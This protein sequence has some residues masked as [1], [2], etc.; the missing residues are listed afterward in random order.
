MARRRRRCM[1]H[2]R[3]NHVA[4][5]FS[6]WSALVCKASSH[7]GPCEWEGRGEGCEECDRVK[8]CYPQE[9]GLVNK[10]ANFI[11]WNS[12]L[13]HAYSGLS[14]HTSDHCIN[15]YSMELI[16]FEFSTDLQRV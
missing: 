8:G 12:E 11:T 7:G 10:N 4:P 13:L 15:I 9:G 3:S 1:F 14:P 2:H 6:F 5:V 16:I